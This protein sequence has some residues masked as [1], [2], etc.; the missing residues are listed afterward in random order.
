MYSSPD[1]LNIEVKKRET[2]VLPIVSGFC[3]PCL[4]M[5]GSKSFIEDTLNYEI[6]DIRKTP[7]GHPVYFFKDY[8]GIMW[9]IKDISD[10]DN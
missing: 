10:K 7:E 1:G 3:N 6:I 4:K 5:E 9:H 8:E 2:H